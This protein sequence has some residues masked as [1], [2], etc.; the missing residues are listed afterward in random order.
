MTKIAESILAELH[1]VAN[2]QKAA[3]LQRFFKTGKGEYA[4]GD[5]MLGITVPQQR[6]IAKIYAKAATLE[7]VDDLL[8]SP[9]HEARLTALFLLNYLY[10]RST[11][12]EK[13]KVHEF[14][15]NHTH[16]INNWDLVD[17]SAHHIVGTHLLENPQA[18]KL[19]TQLAHSHDLWE[20][21]IAIVATFAFIKQG[22]TQ[23]TYT[24]A[25]ELLKDTHDLIH[26]AVGWMMR[27]AGKV[28]EPEL[29]AFLD[30]YAT[31]MPRTMLRYAI[32]KFNPE[33]R[34][35]YLHLK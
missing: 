11:P 5:V 32:E 8:S 35:Y 27:E 24:I 33:T 28:N 19:L 31:T 23:L 2:P 29:K 1:K 13:Q 21:R 20:K 15:L 26:K 22:Q 30:H 16:Y 34:Q 9:F 18:T 12:E 6:Q 7:V 25:Q 3:F 14:Y 4:E 17:S 10:K